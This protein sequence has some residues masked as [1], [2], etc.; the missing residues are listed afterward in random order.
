M[1][2]T[3]PQYRTM[4]QEI[5]ALR[6]KNRTLEI[7]RSNSRTQQKSESTTCLDI[8]KKM[9]DFLRL[10]KEEDEYDTINETNIT[11]RQFRIY[12]MDSI[13]KNTPDNVHID[14]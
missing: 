9:A 8:L 4:K 6:S 5:Q 14:I 12:I 2:R 3:W 10:I 11:L 7:E 13:D 1:P